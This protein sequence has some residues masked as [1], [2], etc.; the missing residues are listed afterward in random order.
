MKDKFKENSSATSASN[1]EH[2]PCA[3]LGTQRHFHVFA[4]TQKRIVPF[5]FSCA[6]WFGEQTEACGDC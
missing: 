6:G 1:T 3:L 4:H 2:T 5:V